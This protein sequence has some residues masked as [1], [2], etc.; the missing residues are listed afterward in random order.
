MIR[1]SLRSARLLESG[2][3][4]TGYRSLVPNRAQRRPVVGAVLKRGPNANRGMLGERGPL[5][6]LPPAKRSPTAR[7]RSWHADSASSIVRGQILPPCAHDPHDDDHDAS[8]APVRRCANVLIE[9]QVSD[10]DPV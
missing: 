10:F 6:P 4:V 1:T 8:L 2:P 9:R 5:G 3:E 7:I